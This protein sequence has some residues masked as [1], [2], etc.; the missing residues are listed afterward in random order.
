MFGNWA[1]LAIPSPHD[2][3]AGNSSIKRYTG[4]LTFPSYKSLTPSNPTFPV[5]PGER[6]FY[7]YFAKIRRAT[8]VTKEHLE[9]LNVE[10]E[11]D[12]PVADMVPDSGGEEGGF[13][14]ERRA[15][16]LIEND[17][18]SEALARTR[19]DIKLG[20][21]YRF[22]Q[23]VEMVRVYYGAPEDDDAKKGEEIAEK[24][25]V[26]LPIGTGSDAASNGAAAK[27]KAEEQ[28]P[29]PDTGALP[30]EKKGKSTDG[31][32]EAAKREE[33]LKDETSKEKEKEKDEE[34]M[35][36]EMPER[37]RE[38]LIK[39]F[40]EPICWGYGVRVY[41]PRAPPKVALQHSKFSVHLNFHIQLTPSTPTEARQGIVEGP[42]CGIQIRHEH[43]FRAIDDVKALQAKLLK[44]FRRQQQQA[45]ASR[46]SSSSS[47][48]KSRRSGSSR[49]S[50]S[51]SRKEKE[52]D[53]NAMD[54]DSSSSVSELKEEEE[55][56]DLI[57]DRG[58]LLVSP[59]TG[60]AEDVL[61]V[62]REIACLLHLA[63]DRAREGETDKKVRFRAIGKEGGK[64]G[65]WDSVFLIRGIH[66]H[67]SISHLKVSTAYLRFL[68]KGKLPR[69]DHPLIAEG[70]NWE[71][72]H[73]KRGRWWDLLVPEQRVE[74]CREI[75]S[76][77]AWLGR[78]EVKV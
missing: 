42:V 70:Q 58:L 49:S 56:M 24:M 33:A 13:F 50:R 25:T 10:V 43:S 51:S 78:S 18:A 45:L 28:M 53:P 52:K 44:Q 14:S 2:S 22:F 6:D 29:V 31:M 41:P 23:S 11:N 55:D 63:Q 7:S 36:F 9:C 26:D 69:K 34:E 48:S 16:L 35:K 60:E 17:A 46:S 72:L 15:E 74:A 57:S 38:E 71:K 65:Y 68:K 39:N 61:G 73:L 21:F 77:L 1:S 62:V 59:S 19:R 64:G 47:G 3:N 8:D 75:V 54:I 40:V 76:V 67:I 5:P 30:V 32:E 20:H 4:R 12:V 27:R 66:H 37:F